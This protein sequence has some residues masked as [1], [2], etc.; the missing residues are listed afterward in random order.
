[1]H[2]PC[3]KIKRTAVGSLLFLWCRGPRDQIQVI[4]LRGSD[5]YLPDSVPAFVVILLF[6]NVLL[7]S[8]SL[9]CTG[10][11]SACISL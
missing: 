7:F 6:K 2:G 10:V 5:F 9:K 11:L 1:V 4:R 8:F 3:V